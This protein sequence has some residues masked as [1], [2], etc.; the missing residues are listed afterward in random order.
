[1]V[2]PLHIFTLIWGKLVTSGFCVR[3]RDRGYEIGNLNVGS[4]GSEIVGWCGGAGTG[5]VIDADVDVT[6]GASLSFKRLS[7]FGTEYDYQDDGEEP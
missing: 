2:I 4:R 5:L 1:M 7:G 6:S 3:C